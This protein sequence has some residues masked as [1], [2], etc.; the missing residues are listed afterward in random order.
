MLHIVGW[1]SII[2]IK[3]ILQEKNEAR[4]QKLLEMVSIRK[5]AQW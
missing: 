3:H 5:K 2:T 4:E 1:K